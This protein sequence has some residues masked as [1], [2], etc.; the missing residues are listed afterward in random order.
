[1]AAALGAGLPIEE[2]NG[3]LVV[4]LGGSR[5]EI[6]VLSLS[7]V[8]HSRVL[9][10][11][12]EG[13]DLAIV[14]YIRRHHAVEIGRPTAEHLKCTLGSAVAGGI[15][16][17]TTAKGRCLRLGV[18]RAVEI[19]AADVQAAIAPHVQELAAAL[20]AAV[21]ALPPELASDVV[22]NGVVLVGGGAE[23]DQLAP[24]LR[25]LT[26]MPTLVAEDP[27]GAVARGAGRILD[28]TS[29][30]ERVAS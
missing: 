13:L 22:E 25:H 12:G 26:T 28:E 9:P 20:V 16:G 5:T 24:A 23:L 6:S 18:P 27:G 19:E 3:H 2:P 14:D 7:G 8:V 30:L 17:R 4:D 21:E 11:G 10:G 15:H 1:V 29:L